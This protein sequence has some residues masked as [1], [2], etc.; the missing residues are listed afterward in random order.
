VIKQRKT[1]VWIIPNNWFLN[2]NRRFIIRFLIKKIG[3]HPTAASYQMDLPY[4]ENKNR[5]KC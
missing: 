4:D 5:H 1:K 2:N 3:L